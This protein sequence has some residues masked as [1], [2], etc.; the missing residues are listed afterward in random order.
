M[1]GKESYTDRKKIEI[2][3]ES[4]D[5]KSVCIELKTDKKC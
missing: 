2:D 4:L 5:E 3:T 1:L